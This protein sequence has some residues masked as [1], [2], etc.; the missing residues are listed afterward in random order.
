[1]PNGRPAST[2]GIAKEASCT[3]KVD[4]ADLKTLP[5]THRATSGGELRQRPLMP[6]GSMSHEA[7]RPGEKETSMKEDGSV[8]S[9]D[10]HIGKQPG[11]FGTPEEK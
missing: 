3:L 6:H 8:Y 10:L 11:E 9:S 5:P 2:H 1:M 7:P 4:P